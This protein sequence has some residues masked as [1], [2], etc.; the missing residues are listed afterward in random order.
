M[1]ADKRIKA[2]HYFDLAVKYTIVNGVCFLLYAWIATSAHPELDLES[3]L[4]ASG[5]MWIVFLVVFGISLG[6]LTTLLFL[7]YSSVKDEFTRR[8]VAQV[9]HEAG[10][11]T[12]KQWAKDIADLLWTDFNYHDSKCKSPEALVTDWVRAPGDYDDEN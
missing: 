2:C 12:D 4:E 6:I 1:I 8:A 5:M 3:A 10:P 11:N 7:G 9:L